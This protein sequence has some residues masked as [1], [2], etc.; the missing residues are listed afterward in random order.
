M[1]V[2]KDRAKVLMVYPKFPPSYWSF[3]ESIK[4]LGLGAVMS[5]TGLATVAAMLPGEHFDVLPIVDLNMEELTDDVL[6]QADLVMISAMIAQKES[7]RGVVSRS[8]RLG[9]TIVAGGPYPTSYSDEVAAMGVDHLVLNEAELTLRPFIE[10]WLNNSAGQIYDERNVR[11]RS[12]VALTREG[13]PVLSESPVPRWDLLK[14]PQYSSLAIQFSRGCPF[15]C[16]FC[17]IT[18]LFG[19]A[20]RTKNPGQIIA[21]LGSIYRTG[22]RGPIFM[23]DDNFIGNR[24]KVRE[25]LPILVDWQSK[26]GQPFTFF[27]EASLDLANDNLRDIR[28]GMVSAGFEEVFCG[29]ESVNPDVLCQMNKKQNRGDLQEKVKILQQSGLEVTGGFIIGSDCDRETVF[30]DLLYFIQQNGIVMAMVGLL[31]AFK[32]TLL[33]ERLASEGRLLAE[34]S[35]NNTHQFDFNFEPKLD[36]RF[37]VEGYVA[38]LEQLYSSRNYYARCRELRKR[39]TSRKRKT[40]VNRSRISAMIK[41]FFLYLFLKPDREFI[42]YALYTLVSSPSK[43]F[44]AFKQAAKLAHFQKITKAAVRAHRY[45][46][47]V[48]SLTE[49]FSKRASALQGDADKCL[50]KLS[51]M[52]QRTVGRAVKIYRSLDPDFRDEAK[53]CLDNCRDRL[54]LFADSYRTKWQDTRV[55]N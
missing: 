20:S 49:R 41:V 8:K 53:I 48:E 19:H 27:T 6:G 30:D 24:S 39:L 33:Y 42:K 31:T 17:D 50:K 3:E 52:E 21:E 10:D 12:A 34:T 46:M 43:I 35:G 55:V 28:E 14:L 29:I 44:E 38:F 45:P 18:A 1:T 32:N 22:W 16:E 36:R 54:R 25:L 11:N 5:P 2:K 9:K 40:L 4:L 7:F 37:L 13:K 23:V 15:N 47:Q 26:H 51:R